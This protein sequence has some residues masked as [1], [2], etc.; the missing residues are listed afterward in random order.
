MEILV[1]AGQSGSGKTAVLQV[2]SEQNY[3]ILEALPAN[4]IADII[5]S[6]DQKK[7]HD[8][9]VAL[10]INFESEADFDANIKA[11]ESLKATHKVKLLYLRANVD[12]LVNRYKEHRKIHPL[13]RVNRI[14]DLESCI[15][16]EKLGQQEF[17]MAADFIIDTTQ[18]TILDLRQILL[19]SL[20]KNQKF[21]INILSF[22]FKYGTVKEADFIFDVRFLPN[23]YYIEKLRALTG[24]EDAVYDYVFSFEEANDYYEAVERLVDIA[25]TGLK[26]EKRVTTSIAF[27]CT[28]GKHRS[29]S[30]ARRL[31][32][33]LEQ[34]HEV[35]IRHVEG[36]RGN[37]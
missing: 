23:P 16:K 14:L 28:G 24:L 19:T 35:V 4:S 27:A 34:N 12:V 1:I 26:K 32:K 2:L 33:H 22:G 17:R 25:I 37:W 30:F 6:L 9:K 10:T 36:N 21:V 15:K 13:Q 3:V 5:A 31:A 11:I 20:D 7:T 18:T 29:V 8:L